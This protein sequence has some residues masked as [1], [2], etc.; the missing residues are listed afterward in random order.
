MRSDEANGDP[1]LG[2]LHSTTRPD[3]AWTRGNIGEAVPG[4]FT[5]LSWSVTGPA[6]DLGVRG[7]FHTIGVLSRREVFSSPDPDLNVA[8]GTRCAGTPTCSTSP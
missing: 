3:R 8:A 1:G 5:P 2:V 7:G 4:L 6:V